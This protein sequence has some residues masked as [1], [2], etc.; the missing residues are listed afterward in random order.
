VVQLDD[1]GTVVGRRSYS[2]T[3]EAR[4]ADRVEVWAD[5]WRLGEAAGAGPRFSVFYD[6]SSGG[7][8]LLSVRAWRT[9]APVGFRSLRVRITEP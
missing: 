5:R 8:R 4:G 9:G 3:I 1:H 7:E 6:F 2:I